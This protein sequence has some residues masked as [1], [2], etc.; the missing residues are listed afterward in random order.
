[1]KNNP[2]L[3]LKKSI[4]KTILKV[5]RKL[6][7][8]SAS[9]LLCSIFIIFEL[10]LFSE[11]SFK[12]FFTTKEVS[13]SKD[14][15]NLFS[16]NIIVNAVA[17]GNTGG[18]SYLIE[19]LING[20]AQKKPNWFFTVLLPS[21][22]SYIKPFNFVHNNIKTIHVS[23]SYSR[24][25]MYVKNILNY[26]LFNQFHDQIEQ[27]LSYNRII[28]NQN[29][30][31]LIFDINA[32]LS[33]QDYHVPKVSIV[34]DLMQIDLPEIF[35]KENKWARTS[36]PIVIKSSD[37]IITVSDF[38]KSRFMDEFDINKKNIQTIHIKLANRLQKKSNH[39]N[40]TVLDKFKLKPKNYIMFSAM[41]RKHKNHKNLLLA[42]GQF[43]QK[44]KSSNLKLVFA[45]TAT[46]SNIKYQYEQLHKICSTEEDYNRI[47]KQVVFTNFVSNEDLE[48]LLSNSLAM[49][50]PSLYEGFGMPI[51]EAMNAGVPVACSN[52]SSLPEIAGNA[53]LFFNPRDINDIEQTIQKITTD[54]NLRE[55]LIQK[56]YSRIKY[57]LDTDSMINQYIKVFEECMKS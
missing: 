48:T 49:F 4:L 50:S 22:S 38:T 19:P 11:S 17:L 12:D 32:S 25:I 54:K 57:F 5:T 45:G 43:L 35:P 21:E 28:F 42:F 55:N 39:I 6:T 44:N 14:R 33:L 40:S 2:K 37:K 13:E 8:F 56:G 3:L 23:Y 20:I 53:A 1:M 10:I 29:S 26:A 30:C 41:M 31:D 9:C 24:S 52:I 34:H 18:I 51:I 7:V 16:K 46:N 36:L 15:S 47:K 27:L